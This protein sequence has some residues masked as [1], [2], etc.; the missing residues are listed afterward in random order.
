[1]GAE[2]SR[3]ADSLDEMK[4]DVAAVNELTK[5]IVDEYGNTLVFELLTP[6]DAPLAK[7]F[8]KAN[9]RVR[10]KKT[11][12][13]DASP[14]TL[15]FKQFY[16]VNALLV[17]H[18][19]GLIDQIRQLESSTGRITNA[20]SS[21]STATTND[22]DDAV[23]C[24]ICFER[25]PDVVLPCSHPFC[26]KCLNEWNTRQQNC[27]LCRGEESADSD[28]WL[29]TTKPSRQEIFNFFSSFIDTAL[30]SLD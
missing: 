3:T 25:K 19:D 26:S 24:V 16:A 28:A 29:L 4:R 22:N 9:A 5:R 8:W 11:P 7:L 13:S 21:S 18:R 20:S 10:V 2:Q 12:N 6:P 1:M 30:K 14:Q 23:E 15:T 27:P 17:Q